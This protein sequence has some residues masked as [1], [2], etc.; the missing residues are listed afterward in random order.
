MMDQDKP[1]HPSKAPSTRTGEGSASVMLRLNPRRA[2][3][4]LSTRTI[5]EQLTAELR[6]TAVY[7]AQM[8]EVFEKDYSAAVDLN[9]RPRA[10]SL[11]EDLTALR[12]LAELAQARLAAALAVEAKGNASLG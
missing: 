3:Q 12:E 4:A 6:T 10:A 2:S 8:V 9:D 1:D 5:P 11:L 7:A